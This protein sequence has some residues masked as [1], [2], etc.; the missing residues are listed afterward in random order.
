MLEWFSKNRYK[1]LTWAVTGFVLFYMYACESQVRSLNNGKR[2]VNRAELQAEFNYFIDTADI[3]FASLDRQDKI[4]AI[5]LNNALIVMQG[6]PF[7]PVGL[8]TAILGVYGVQ[9][10]A[11]NTTGAIKNARARRANNKSAPA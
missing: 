7:N 2:L 11:K 9:Q 5:V 8:I 1:I 6:Q 4:R 10:A 3:R